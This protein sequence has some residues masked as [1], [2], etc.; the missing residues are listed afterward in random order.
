M[1][2]GYHIQYSER[3][4]DFLL[5]AYISLA[6][7]PHLPHVTSCFALPENNQLVIILEK[8]N[9][10]GDSFCATGIFPTTSFGINTKGLSLTTVSMN[11]P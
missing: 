8:E 1:A 11:N 10:K 5:L 7:A 4:A 6:F 9:E 2:V 3:K